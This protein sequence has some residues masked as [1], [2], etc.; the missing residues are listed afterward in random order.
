MR[1]F[2]L[3][4][5]VGLAP[6]L[7]RAGEQ[8]VTVSPRAMAAVNA[9][10]AAPGSAM[11]TVPTRYSAPGVALSMLPK[12]TYLG[13][14]TAVAGAM[15]NPVPVTAMG[16]SPLYFTVNQIATAA[17]VKSAVAVETKVAT[18]YDGGVERAALVHAAP[19]SQTVVPAGEI[20][21]APSRSAYLKQV[22]G[23]SGAP[24]RDSLQ[25]IMARQHKGDG[26]NDTKRQLLTMLAREAPMTDKG[27]SARWEL[28]A[29][30][31]YQHRGIVETPAAK[32]AWLSQV[33]DLLAW[34]RR[35]PPTDEERALNDRREELQGD[36]N[37][38]VDDPALA[39]RISPSVFKR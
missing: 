12:N 37:P 4:A 31:L 14:N 35:H 33:D 8:G 15:A 22:R 17:A 24:L 16:L 30:V 32:A 1:P 34:N 11:S 3:I 28:A 7:A 2:L 38:F 36:R 39:D 6:A 21:A 19:S 23:L 5:A 10:N 20:S 29:Y 25:G 13:L 27:V 18:A 9:V 26:F